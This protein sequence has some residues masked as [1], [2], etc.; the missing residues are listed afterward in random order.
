MK[1]IGVNLNTRTLLLSSQWRKDE[2][3]YRC[4]FGTGWSALR[5]TINGPDCIVGA[6]E[7]SGK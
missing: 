5:T 2:S 7:L 4:E 1:C 6:I 3:L